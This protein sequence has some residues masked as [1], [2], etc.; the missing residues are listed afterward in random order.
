MSKIR[1]SFQFPIIRNTSRTSSVGIVTPYGLKNRGIVVRFSAEVWDLSLFRRALAGSNIQ[2]DSCSMGTE[3][4]SQGSKRLNLE[5]GHLFLHSAGLKN[6]WRY[7]STPPYAFMVWGLIKN[8]G[9]FTFI[10]SNENVA[11]KRNCESGSTLAKLI[12]CTEIICGDW[13]WNNMQICWGNVCVESKIATW[14]PGE[15]LL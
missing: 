6:A 15:N 12:L 11:N 9:N 14:R 2:T 5:G 13:L 8:R 7:A 4:S 10:I 1:C 3:F